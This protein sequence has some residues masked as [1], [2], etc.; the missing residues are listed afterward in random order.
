[1]KNL[2][3]DFKE[4]E[5]QS[6]LSKVQR[7]KK[8]STEYK[9]LTSIQ[10]LGELGKHQIEVNLIAKQRAHEQRA[11]SEETRNSLLAQAAQELRIADQKR[12]EAYMA[13][14]QRT[15]QIKEKG[16]PI[17]ND[18]YNAWCAKHPNIELKRQHHVFKYYL[19][20][21][22]VPSKVAI[23][24]DGQKY[25]SLKKHRNS[26]YARQHTIEDDGWNFVR[27]TGSQAWNDIE[28]CVDRVFKVISQRMVGQG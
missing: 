24:I 8:D 3:H 4:Y 20:F 12:Q 21:A 7:H 23:E 11:N 2:W 26:D 25:H 9:Q 13:T 6:R 28:S 16:I 15:Q 22:H 14:R 10:T 18:F 5:A 19:D 1:M 17:E 27:F